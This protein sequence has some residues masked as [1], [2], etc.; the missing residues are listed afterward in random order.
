[1]VW[2]K[3]DDK[4]HGHR[5]TLALFDGPCPGDAIALWAL[6]ASWCGDQLTDGV[7]PLAFVRRSGLDKKAADELVRVGLWAREA[8]CFV[9]H[10]WLARNKSRATVEADRVA[11]L[12]RKANGP[13]PRGRG[14]AEPTSTVREKFARTSDEPPPEFEQSSPLPDPDPIP[15]EAAAASQSGAIPIRTPF[16]ADMQLSPE[17]VSREWHAAAQLGTL[18]GVSHWVSDYLTIAATIN[19][20]P[21]IRPENRALMLRKLCRWIHRD[22]SGPVQCGRLP[23]SVM[24]DRVAKRCAADL[25]AAD[26]SEWEG[27]LDAAS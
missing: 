25:E 14:S 7:V 15:T 19:G 23:K 3:L 22:P 20:H 26:K 21:K 12:E 18:H 27:M 11:A 6:A 10:D 17:D 13:K 16:L 9:F 5:K 24:P 8:D 1:M 4:F 2:V